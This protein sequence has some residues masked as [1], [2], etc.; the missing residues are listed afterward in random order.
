MSGDP[1][2]RV[3]ATLRRGVLP[4]PELLDAA[5]QQL[6]RDRYWLDSEAVARDN[7]VIWARGLNPVA[8]M[9]K[10]PKRDSRWE[11]RAKQIDRMLELSRRIA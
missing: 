10:P 8:A 4:A 1:V 7:R 5:G 11:T 2:F 3:I 9:K 6:A